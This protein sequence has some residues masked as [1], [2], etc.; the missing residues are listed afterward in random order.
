M[1]LGETVGTDDPAEVET[2]GHMEKSQSADNTSQP[3]D[4]TTH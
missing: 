1:R 3:Q 2:C 4:V